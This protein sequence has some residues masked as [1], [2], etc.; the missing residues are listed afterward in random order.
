M[1]PSEQQA[2]ALAAVFQAATLVVELAKNGVLNS[3]EDEPL[4]E[5]LF[6]QNPDDFNDIYGRPS[7]SLNTG[8]RQL[9]KACIDQS[10]ANPDISR[11]VLSMLHLESKVSKSPQ[12]L[13]A[14][15]AGIQDT[16]RQAE[17]FSPTH[18][19]TI[20]SLA[21]LYKETLSQLSFRIKVTGDPTHL[22]NPSVANEIRSLLFAGIRAAILWRQVGGRRWHLLFYRKR[23]SLLA[24]E[25]LNS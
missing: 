1:K 5:S 16:S 19:N 25:L 7:H 10:N 20:A 17:H 11:Y 22:Q 24:S 13:D 8:L 23:Y 6:I 3:K 9:K 15:G 18:T 2:I 14:I 21:E 4:I 12:L